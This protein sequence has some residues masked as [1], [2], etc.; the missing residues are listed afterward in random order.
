MFFQETAGQRLAA[1][2]ISVSLAGM[3]AACGGGSDTPPPAAGGNPPPVTPPAEPTMTVVGEVSGWASQ[4]AGTTGGANAPATN[5]Y[6]VTNRTEL[7]AA[8]A[9][10]S[11]PTYATNQT[12]AKSEPKIIYVVGSIYGTDLGNGSKADMAWYRSQSANAAK[13]DWDLYI[14][15]LDDAFM[16]DLNAKV[17]ASDSAAIATKT[18]IA[19]LSTGRTTIMNLQKAQIQFP[20]T[21][22]TS[23][24]GVG[25]NAKLIDGYLAISSVNNVIVRNIEFEA[26]TDLATAYQGGAHP[27]WNARY[28]AI[29]IGT[30][31]QVWIDHVTL[32]D[33]Q[34][35][36]TELLTINGVTMPVQRHDGLLDI[37]DG[38]DYITVSYT[39]FK[40]HDKTNMV[41]GS[42]DS[43]GFK[44]RDVN[45]LTFSHNRWKDSAQRAPR[46]RFG[47]IHV[48]NNYYSGNTDAPTYA[49]GYYIGMG[50][51]SRILSE[52]NAFDI[53][54]SKASIGYVIENWNGYQFKD[55]GSWYNG[56]PSSAALEATAKAELEARWSDAQA[57]SASYGFT[58]AAYTNELGWTPPYNYT[59]APTVTALRKHVDA[60][61]GAGKLAIELPAAAATP[62]PILPPPPVTNSCP[63]DWTSVDSGIAGGTPFPAFYA[64]QKDTTDLPSNAG[65]SYSAG[66]YTVTAGGALAGAGDG[67]TM[68][69]K[70]VTGNFTLVAK[71]ESMEVPGTLSAAN[72]VAGVM[73]RN[74]TNPRSLYY[75]MM[76]RGNK[77]LRTNFRD[78]SCAS[79]GNTAVVT[80]PSMPTNVS[81]LW[82]K[83]TRTGQV[84]QVSYSY[85]GSTWVDAPAKDFSLT[86]PLGA[87]VL[88][89]LAGSSGTNSTVSTY[90][91]FSGV[92]LTP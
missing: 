45:R 90:S 11:S 65:A 77:S 14:Q 57:A 23:I 47:R 21:S 25:N 68:A 81:P 83:L 9:N 55:V 10:T 6:R 64:F 4:G 36:D 27:E 40:N 7:L 38:S 76:L 39:E 46:A 19:D 24:I 62:G 51:E 41:G 16:A 17:A 43:N 33:G 2:V 35:Q 18:R 89:G 28:D 5:I 86:S 66:T 91:V 60:N 54:G 31:K 3:L 63:A 84:V 53:A 73:L 52:T 44:E 87:E 12:A 56:T 34:N 13:W 22:N 78:T 29:S 79:A 32:S 58:L 71:L 74:D 59:P 85:D 82:M 48:Y 50:A 20:V 8:L 37:E 49:V 70:K 88:V 42:G 1:F 75:S 72:I 26:P 61:A 80:I 67:L 15:S 92:S 69:Y 30:A